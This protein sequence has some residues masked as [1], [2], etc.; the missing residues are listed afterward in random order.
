MVKKRQRSH[1]FIKQEIKT[2]CSNYRPLSILSSVVKIFEK[3]SSNQL[4]KHLENTGMVA[5]QQSGFK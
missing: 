2:E 4:S 5:F 3:L 1:L